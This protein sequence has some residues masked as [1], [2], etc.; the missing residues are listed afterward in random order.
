MELPADIQTD[1]TS[2][3]PV[4]AVEAFEGET[5][6]QKITRLIPKPPKLNFGTDRRLNITKGIHVRLSTDPKSGSL[7]VS[8]AVYEKEQIGR[9]NTLIGLLRG[10]S[11]RPR[12]IPEDKNVVRDTKWKTHLDIE[13]NVNTRVV[14]ELDIDNLYFTPEFYRFNLFGNWNQEQVELVFNNFD[15]GENLNFITFDVNAK[16][17]PPVASSEPTEKN[18]IKMDFQTV[19]ADADIISCVNGQEVNRYTPITIDPRIWVNSEG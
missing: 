17:I 14:Y 13:A 15:H 4:C 2:E 3:P 5:I 10:S 6:A 16:A 11:S 1:T 12:S 18:A 9:I 19:M 7:Q 8:K